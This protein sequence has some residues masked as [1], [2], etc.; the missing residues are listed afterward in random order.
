MKRSDFESRVRDLIAAGMPSGEARIRADVEAGGAGD[1]VDR[2]LPHDPCETL[3]A[4]GER[5][6]PR[7]AARSSPG[8]NA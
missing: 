1:I 6:Q 5:W 2:P 4:L 7:Q 8:Q 3:D